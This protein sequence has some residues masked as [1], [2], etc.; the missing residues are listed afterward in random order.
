VTNFQV[1]AVQRLN[2]ALAIHGNK[3]CAEVY[4]A[5]LAFHGAGRAANLDELN[6]ERGGVNHSTRGVIVE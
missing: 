5:D 1:C 6:L 4:E 2:G 3:D